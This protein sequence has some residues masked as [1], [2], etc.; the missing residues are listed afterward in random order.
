MRDDLTVSLWNQVFLQGQT[1]DAFIAG[2]NTFMMNDSGTSRTDIYFYH[3]FNLLTTFLWMMISLFSHRSSME[4]RALSIGV[5]A[6]FIMSSTS[7][8]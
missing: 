4:K 6:W 8:F 5:L 3:A 7:A 2:K 1:V